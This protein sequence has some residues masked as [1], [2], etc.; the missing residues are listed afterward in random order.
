MVYVRFTYLA[1][2]ADSSERIFEIDVDTIDLVKR[3]HDRSSNTS[4]KL[5]RSEGKI[6]RSLIEQLVQESLG[7]LNTR[8]NFA[9]LLQE[10]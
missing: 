10:T 8:E 1:G 4:E 7:D 3:A 6:L 5:S 9:R 2:R